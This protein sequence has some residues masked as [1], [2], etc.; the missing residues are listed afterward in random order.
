MDVADLR[1]AV[2][3]AR[4]LQQWVTGKR[5]PA[6]A[7]LNPLQRRHV[8][9]KALENRVVRQER[10][11]RGTYVPPRLV[12]RFLLDAAAG[13]PPDGRPPDALGTALDS[14]GG[15]LGLDRVGSKS[16]VLD[17]TLE[18]QLEARFD[19]PAETV[20]RVAV[21]LLGAR[22]LTETLIDEISDAAV[23]D[24][25][26][27]DNTWLVADVVSIPRVPTSRE[28]DR[29]VAAR[30]PAL[31]DYYARHPRLFRTPERAVVRLLL[32]ESDPDASA[33]E[34]ARARAQ[35]LRHRIH[36]GASFEALARQFSA[37]PSAKRGGSMGAV[38]R[39]KMPAAFEIPLGQLS[40]VKRHDRGWYFFRVERRIPA[41]ERLLNT[42]SV[43][44]EIAAALLSQDDEL[45][46]ARSIAGKARSLLR[47]EPQGRALAS[48]VE[49]ARLKRETTP[50]FGPAT[51]RVPTVGLAPNLVGAIVA[52]TPEAPVTPI[53]T[54]RQH[55]IVARLADSHRPD[56]STWPSQ[57]EAYTRQWRDRQR[58]VAIDEWLTTRLA[59]ETLWIDMPALMALSL[60]EL[61]L[62]PDRGLEMER[63]GKTRRASP[64]SPEKTR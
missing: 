4:V 48:L 12:R 11:R 44:R 29:A 16:T 8:L 50:R 3:E 36:E 19:A 60:E 35:K 27:Q 15:N 33:G 24:S 31:A 17:N 10:Q 56:L 25:W 2:G 51:D 59:S 46:H 38:A 45:P 42:P 47:R 1:V 30:Q 62:E 7:L 26:L 40:P 58:R 54:V 53:V 43:Q 18:E 21:D 52:L 20:R 22:L 32:I 6:R 64:D 23:R 61:G 28:I 5:P 37:D 49:E 9:K 55:Y 39:S 13:R 41:Y 63:L 57:R 34:D 14:Q